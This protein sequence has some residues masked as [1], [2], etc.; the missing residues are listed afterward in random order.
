MRSV[1]KTAFYTRSDIKF[2][3][4]LNRVSHGKLSKLIDYHFV[5]HAGNGKTKVALTTEIL[6]SFIT[7][8]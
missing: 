3:K 2:L 1:R 7:Y 8:R 5:V 4:V 6:A